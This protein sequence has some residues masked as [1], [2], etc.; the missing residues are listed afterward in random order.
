M[1]PDVPTE[2]RTP[3]TVE[4]RTYDTLADVALLMADHVEGLD[5]ANGKIVATDQILTAAETKLAGGPEE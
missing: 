2:L 1:V 5:C 3:C 4:A